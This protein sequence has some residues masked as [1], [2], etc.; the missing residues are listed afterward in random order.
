MAALCVFFCPQTISLL[1]LGGAT[2]PAYVLKFQG[3]LVFL[4]MFISWK[5]GQQT[6]L[7]QMLVQCNQSVIVHAGKGKLY[8]CCAVETDS[9]LL[10]CMLFL[11]NLKVS[12]Q[13]LFFFSCLSVE[14]QDS[15]P[16]F[17]KCWCSG[18]K[19]L[20]CT[21][22]KGN[23]IIA[24]LLKPTAFDWF[25]CFSWKTLKESLRCEQGSNLRGETPLDFESNALTSRPSQHSGCFSP[26]FEE[27]SL[28]WNGNKYCWQKLLW[29]HLFRWFHSVAVI[30]S[31][32]HAEGPGFNPQWN[33]AF[34]LKSMKACAW[35]M[36]I[37]LVTLLLC[38]KP[39]HLLNA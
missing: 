23:F 1:N 32:L 4:L 7:F 3:K 10:V 31:A 8:Y 2:G 18:I 35:L 27:V 30:T 5:T 26:G 16:D 24:V 36:L 29:V 22:G 21:T 9:V 15:R 11:E 34:V 38:Q 13:A 33:H 25:A 6:W 37:E 28:L 17:F 19:V 39:I 20:K 12:E 14:R